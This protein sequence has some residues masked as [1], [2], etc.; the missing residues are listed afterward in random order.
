MPAMLLTC[1]VLKLD[2]LSDCNEEQSENIPSI[3]STRSVVKLDKLRD[4]NEEQPENMLPM[5]A[6]CSVFRFSIPSISLRLSL[7]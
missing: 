2:K 1:S 6:T 3:F 7:P 5:F 4:A